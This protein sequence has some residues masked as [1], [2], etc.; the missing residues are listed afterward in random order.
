MSDSDRIT[1]WAAMITRW[2]MLAGVVTMAVSIVFLAAPVW[3]LSHVMPYGFDASWVA[4]DDSFRAVR[5]PALLSLLA[6]DIALFAIIGWQGRWSHLTRRLGIAIGI[7]GIVILGFVAGHKVLASGQ[8]DGYVRIVIGFI[9]LAS[10]Y[11]LGRTI[12][13]EA[14]LSH[15]AERP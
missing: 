4:Y 5:L 14:R 11:N 15:D 1:Q 6:A 9:L 8:I 2:M 3:S 10:L 12:F 7:A 13:H